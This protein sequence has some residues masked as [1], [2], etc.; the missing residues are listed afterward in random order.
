MSKV[1]FLETPDGRISYETS[2]SGPLVV[3]VPGMGDLR[4]SY[5]EMVTPL[6]D[7]G[8]RVA[9]MDLRGHG[10]SDTTFD[11]YGDIA[12]ARDL[13]ALI[14]KLGSPAVVLGSSIGG[15]AAAYAA[16]ER[17]D[18]VAGLVLYGPLLREPKTTPFAHAM[19]RVA[20]RVL[21][22]RPWGAGAWSRYYPKFNTGRPAE[23]RPEG[24]LAPWIH[25]HTDAIRRMLRQPGRLRAFRRLT[26]QLD[27][28]VVEPRLSDIKAPMLVF[29]GESDPDFADQ[30]AELAWLAKN[31]AETELVLESGHYPH[32]QRPD[33]VVPR[34]LAFIARLRGPAWG[35]SA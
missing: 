2:G 31:G 34:T 10:D 3:A 16:A 13:I 24:R 35:E 29:I 32:A 18:A 7:A 14:D 33:V 6:V 12:L 30:R 11:D 8:Y 5:R 9:I 4:S 17:P 28:S 27:H 1:E 25:E 20:Y 19:T 22:S 21:F 15:S 26:L 23:G